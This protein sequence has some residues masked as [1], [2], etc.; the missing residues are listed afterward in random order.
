MK[1]IL[2]CFL[3]KLGANYNFALIFA[4][5]SIIPNSYHNMF[6]DK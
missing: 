2:V 6:Y 5:L 1:Q 4:V 3:G